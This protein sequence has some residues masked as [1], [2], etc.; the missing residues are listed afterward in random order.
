MLAL[1]NNEARNTVN[2][3]LSEINSDHLFLDD[4]GWSASG[5]YTNKLP[6]ETADSEM[7]T[8]WFGGKWTFCG[9]SI[10]DSKGND[11]IAKCAKK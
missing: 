1:K 7:E 10:L 4:L 8:V 9:F 2:F 11:A 5:R 6:Y 3:N